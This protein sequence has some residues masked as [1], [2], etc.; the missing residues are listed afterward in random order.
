MKIFIFL[1]AVSFVQLLSSLELNRVILSSNNDPK[2]IQFWPVVAPVWQK[3]GLRPT[4]MLVADDNCVVDESLGDVIR[5]SPLPD[6][7]ESLQAQAIRLL[8]PALFPNDGCLISDIDMIPIS[9]SY[10]MDGALPCPPSAFLVYRDRAHGAEYPRWP[11]CYV[12]ARGDVFASIFGVSK[13][14][15][16]SDVLRFFASLS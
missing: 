3:M 10:F 15:D 6:F 5:F 8:A 14:E 13:I 12:A 9:R 16:F 11:M 2:Y 7:S 1:C 4:L